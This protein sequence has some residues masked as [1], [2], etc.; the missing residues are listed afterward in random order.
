MATKARRSLKRRTAALCGR[1]LQRLSKQLKEKSVRMRREEL[2]AQL[3]E[4]ARKGEGHHVTRW[5]RSI[6]I[7]L[8][9]LDGY[10]LVEDEGE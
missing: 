4:L 5:R 9:A 2:A 1:S 10:A 8:A 6:L 7:G 3:L